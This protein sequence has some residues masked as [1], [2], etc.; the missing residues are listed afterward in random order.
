MSADM[1]AHSR[2]DE[3][4]SQA[5]ATDVILTGDRPTGR[6][7]SA[8]SVRPDEQPQSFKDT[9]RQCATATPARLAGR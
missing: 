4:R 6:G 8:V 1:L 9:T 2:A 5:D 7:L 3:R